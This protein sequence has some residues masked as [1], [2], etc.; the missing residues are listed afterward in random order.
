MRKGRYRK[1]C[2]FEGVQLGNEC[3]GVASLLCRDP[4][5]TSKPAESRRL[6]V[7]DRFQNLAMDEGFTN[8]AADQPHGN[9]FLYI[10]IISIEVA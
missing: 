2:F 1:R 10:L 6:H 8:E 9:G 4:L 5:H 3:N 7:L